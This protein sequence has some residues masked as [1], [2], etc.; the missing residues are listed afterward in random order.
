MKFFQFLCILLKLTPL[1]T[2]SWATRIGSL[3]MPLSFFYQRRLRQKEQNPFSAESTLMCS[4]KTKALSRHEEAPY[5]RPGLSL[6][7]KSEL[8]AASV[9]PRPPSLSSDSMN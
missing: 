7:S 1:P 2:L 5:P 6:R 8:S 9:L 3:K 4:Q